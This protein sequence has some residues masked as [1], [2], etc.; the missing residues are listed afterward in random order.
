MANVWHLQD[1]PVQSSVCHLIVREEKLELCNKRETKTTRTRMQ[2]QSI[3]IQ[4]AENS[5]IN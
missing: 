1:Y 2:K 5:A 4:L 3:Y